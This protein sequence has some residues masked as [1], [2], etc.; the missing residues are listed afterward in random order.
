MATPRLGR[1]TSPEDGA[2]KAILAAAETVTGLVFDTDADADADADAESFVAEDSLSPVADE[3]KVDGLVDRPLQTARLQPLKFKP[4]SPPQNS[5]ASTP[6]KASSPTSQHAGRP[7]RHRKGAAKAAH[8]PGQPVV[9]RKP[10]EWDVWKPTLHQLYITQ[11]RILRDI[12]G[13]METKYN[14]RAT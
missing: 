3:D 10:E 6:G 7:G 8:V 14:V 9:P 4:A 12:I 13:I 11:N 2:A 5:P 1:S